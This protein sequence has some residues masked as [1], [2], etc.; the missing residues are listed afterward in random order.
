MPATKN[1]KELTLKDRLS[2]LNFLQAKKLLGEGSERFLIR[3]GAW[4][5]NIDEQVNLNDDAFCLCFGDI[6][7]RIWLSD[8]GRRRLL[9]DCS[10]GNGVCEHIGAAVSLILEE[11]MAL[12]LSALRPDMAP[13]GS[14]TE[15]EI[16]DRAIADRRTRAKEER[17][18]VRSSNPQQIW[19]DYLVT[20]RTSGR[21]YRVALR[22]FEP[23]VS[24][25]SCPDFRKNTLGVCKHIFRV[26]NWTKRKFNAQQ[27]SAPYVR[28][29]F[30]V[31]VDYSDQLALRLLAPDQIPLETVD[32]AGPLLNRPIQDPGDLFNRVGQIE[33]CGYPV[34]IYPDAEE[35]IQAR[36][37]QVRLARLSEEI[38]QDPENHTLRT[39]LLH[40][41]LLPYQLDGI[42]FA[43]GAGRAV[44]A[45]D[46]GLGKTIQGIGIAELLARKVGIKKV[47][48]VCP[49]SLKSQWRSEISR[50]CDRSAAPV[51]GAAKERAKQY[52]GDAF[53]TICNYEQV[54]RDILAIERVKWDL[55][56]LDEGQRI[57]NWEAKTTRV[58][59]GLQSPFALV[60][61]GTPLENRLDDLFSIVEFIDDRRLGPA[62]RFF[63]RHRVVDAFGKVLGY[64]GLDE[65]R[66]KLRPVLLRRTRSSVMQQLPARTTTIER[67]EPTKEQLQVHGSFMQIVQQ[68]VRKEY[69]TEMDLLRLQKALL[70]CRLVANSTFLVNRQKKQAYSSKLERLDELFRGFA[71]EPDRKVVL[72]SEWTTMLDLIEPLLEKNGLPFVRLD[73][74]VPQKK[75]QGLVNQF[76]TDAGCRF[77]ITT[78]AGST[79]LNLQM[80]NT[81]VNV[82]LP[83]NPAVLEQRIS[84]AHRMGQQNPVQVYL[85]VTEETIEENLLVTL[86]A[87][88]ELALAALDLGSEVSMVELESGMEELKRRLEKLLG[89]KQQAPEHKG[90]QAETEAQMRAV[91]ERKEKLSLAGGQ[92]L[93]AAFGFMGEMLPEMPTT[94]QSEALA[95]QLR[96]SMDQCIEK[97]EHGRVKLTVTLPDAAILDTLAQNLA[98]LLP[99][100]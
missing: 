95:N 48:V 59:K 99:A 71:A 84:R 67:I 55:I 38:R 96:K 1:S 21:A 69:L 45:D 20:N 35:L 58:I 50:F 83:W 49:A 16:I 46:M 43:V 36:S 14:L 10:C 80:A 7:A 47:L 91:A 90:Q 15:A 86:S 2:R 6:E 28:Q 34:A 73:G 26:Q 61:T 39:T 100:G 25:C 22:G 11:K 9:F 89:A 3:G 62:F 42:A 98:R 68:I 57:K 60:L 94:P 27:R 65:V 17:M 77:F 66:E 33:G 85:L 82:D 81:V 31:I 29:G 63:N 32:I 54:L 76:Q 87:K 53:F 72:F 79:G 37:L 75:R 4:D 88:H 74:S 30:S 70:M 8:R 51:L 12:G 40:A 19:T 44:L 5:I 24:F 18:E 93:Q 23:G 56:I 13:L 92:L 52:A 78:N 97:D 64:E 41:E